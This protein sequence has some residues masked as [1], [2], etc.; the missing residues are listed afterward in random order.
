LMNFITYSR[1]INFYGQTGAR[2]ANDQTI[3]GSQPKRTYLVKVLSVLFFY[4]P[5]LHLRGLESVYTDFVICRH[6]WQQ[7]IT[8]LQDDWREF[9][10][11]GTVLLN[12]NVAFLTI[13]SVDPGNH[14]R[15]P[16]QL[17]SYLSVISSIGSIVVGL[18]LLRQHRTKP[19]DST[20]E[21][22][23]YLRSRHRDALGFETLAILYSLP[24]SLLLW[25]TV[26]FLSAF[27]LEALLFSDG[28]WTRLPVGVVLVMILMLISWCI[29]TTLEAKT[30]FSVLISFRDLKDRLV[31]FT[32]GA[33]GKTS[34]PG[35]GAGDD[36]GQ[37]R[38]RRLSRS[39]TFKDALTRFRPRRS[40]ASTAAT[41]VNGRPGA[42]VKMD[43]IKRDDS[44]S[45]V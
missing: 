35:P 2:L 11:Y 39:E 37:G 1:Y 26:A 7:F 21:V 23:K 30:D 32:Q 43:K 36:G 17:A 10:L 33:R 44:G 42:A 31:G 41:L 13:P 25:A 16:A 9:I 27:G 15:S 12:A 34:E 38:I 22:E 8:R 4:A 3:Y 18:L 45:A 19:H 40:R 14:T 28:L 20:E 5:E 6:R 29:W 24:Y